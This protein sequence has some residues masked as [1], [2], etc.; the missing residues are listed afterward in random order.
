M[1]GKI[2]SHRDAIALL[3]QQ[4]KNDKYKN[5]IENLEDSDAFI[6]LQELFDELVDDIDGQGCYLKT[7]TMKESIDTDNE[8]AKSI[9]EAYQ[10][11]DERGFNGQKEN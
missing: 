1:V 5:D 2:N 8:H 11:L 9:A 7:V 6:L 3:F 10:L 4:L